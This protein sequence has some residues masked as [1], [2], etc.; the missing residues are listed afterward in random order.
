MCSAYCT[1]DSVKSMLLCTHSKCQEWWLE[2][3]V[4]HDEITPC[5]VSFGIVVQKNLLECC[6]YWWTPK[7]LTVL[8][9][10]VFE[11]QQCL[12]ILFVLHFEYENV[13][14]NTLSGL[15]PSYLSWC[16][17]LC[18]NSHSACKCF[19]TVQMDWWKGCGPSG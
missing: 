18:S 17:T 16:A 6:Q 3:Y 5:I 1:C 4:F 2:L 7:L 13:Y 19:K 14:A 12:M 9:T 10:W 15:I 11:R 8:Q